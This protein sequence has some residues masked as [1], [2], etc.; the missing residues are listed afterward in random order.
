MLKI[1]SSSAVSTLMPLGL[2]NKVFVD[3]MLHLCN[4]GRENLCYMKR[5]SPL[6]LWINRYVHLARDVKTKNNCG[7]GRNDEQSQQGRMRPILMTACPVKSFTKYVLH[8]HPL[9]MQSGNIR[10]Q[11]LS[12]VVHGTTITILLLALIATASNCSK[13]YTNQPLPMGNF[14]S[15]TW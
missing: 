9:V 7:E 12:L 4:R 15:Q 5:E 2:Q 6:T 14:S 1:K 11:P 13:I 10:K 8:L 3:L